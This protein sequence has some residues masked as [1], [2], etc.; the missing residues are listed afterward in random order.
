MRTA[1]TTAIHAARDLYIRYRGRD[2]RRIERDMRAMGFASFTRR[3]LYDTRQ[4]G[5][6]TR[7]G[8]IRRYGFDTQLPTSEAGSTAKTRRRTDAEGGQ[9]LTG[10]KRITRS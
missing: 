10:I 8:W 7:I 9:Q 3:V 1:N 4:N 2:H 5:Q 6:L